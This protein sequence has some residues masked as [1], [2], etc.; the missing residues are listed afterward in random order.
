[1]QCNQNTLL[2][3]KIHIPMYEGLLN[4]NATLLFRIA[5]KLLSNILYDI[6]LGFDVHFKQ[7]FSLF[8]SFTSILFLKFYIVFPYI[9]LYINLY[10]AVPSL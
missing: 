3:S 2:N 1:M 7:S 9:V 5:T 6:W 4:F 10:N 8:T